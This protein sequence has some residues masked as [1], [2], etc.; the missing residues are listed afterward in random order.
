MACRL[1]E[2]MLEKYYEINQKKKEIETAMQ[3]MERECHHYFDETV[4]K[5]VK[6]EVILVDYK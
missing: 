1:T 3:E 2:E 5:N 4:G 6:G